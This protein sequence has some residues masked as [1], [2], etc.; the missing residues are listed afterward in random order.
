MSLKLQKTYCSS[1]VLKP[2][3]SDQETSE[4]EL[5]IKS[6]Q[7]SRQKE[8]YWDLKSKLNRSLT[9]VVFVETYEIRNSRFDFRPMLV[10][11]YRVSFLITLDIYK[12]YF[13]GRCVCRKW[14]SSLFS[15]KKLLRFYAMGFVTK[16]LPDLHHWW[17]EELCSQHLLQV[18]GVNH[19]LGSV[20]HWLVTY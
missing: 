16:E 6:Q 17:T 10:Y 19:V 18:I 20:H 13:K 11:L 1:Q 15:L 14:P 7:Q 4:E 3:R 12:A 2:W 8:F 5:F 9:Q